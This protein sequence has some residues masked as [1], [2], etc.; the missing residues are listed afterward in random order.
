[1]K[2][3]R[4]TA[5]DFLLGF[6]VCDASAV[7][8]EPAGQRM[9][10]PHV[11]GYTAPSKLPSNRNR[12]R[13]PAPGQR[14]SQVT[15]KRRHP[16][17]QTRLSRSDWLEAARSALIAGGIESVKVDRLAKMLNV[18]RGGFYWHFTDR[19]DLLD[20][21]LEHWE[22]QTNQM[23][24]SVL[25]QDHADGAAEFTAL[26]NAWIEEDAYSPAYDSAVRDWARNS[27]HVAKAVRRVD[28]HRIEILQ[29]IFK[30]LGYAENEAFIR[31]RI[32]YFHQVGY[33][34]LGLDES[35]E[36]RRG[37]LP[38]YVDALTGGTVKLKPS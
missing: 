37:L 18:T 12:A 9:K 38:D 17:S 22:R 4:Q 13:K 1:M 26:A 27:D 19:K 6:A 2:R 29:R 32:T 15:T 24:E 3:L 35:K 11:R 30:D 25:I 23:F 5:Q 14:E 20:A 36:A 28:N 7:A 34:T 31:A 8:I 21:L 33:Y 10:M 16:G